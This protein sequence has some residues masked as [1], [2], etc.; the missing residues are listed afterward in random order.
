MLRLRVHFTQLKNHRRWYNYLG[1]KIL[2]RSDPAVSN[3]FSLNQRHILQLRKRSI[4]YKSE[5]NE[6]ISCPRQAGEYSLVAKLY[7]HIQSKVCL[8]I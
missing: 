8:Q 2:K 1:T 5:D 6:R 3:Q 4:L 7:I